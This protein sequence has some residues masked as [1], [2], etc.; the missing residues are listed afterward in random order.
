MIAL[1]RHSNSLQ[2]RQWSESRVVNLLRNHMEKGARQG[3]MMLASLKRK[4]A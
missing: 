2:I 4:R 3:L 1:N